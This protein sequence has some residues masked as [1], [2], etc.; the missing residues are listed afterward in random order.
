MWAPD[1]DH[2]RPNEMLGRRVF[3]DKP[4]VESG[5]KGLEGHFK[6]DIFFDRRL[7]DDLSVDRLGEGSPMKAVRRFLT[8]LARAQGGSMEPPRPFSGWAAISMKKLGFVEVMAAPTD[9]PRNPYHAEIS[10]ALFRN[11][12]QA[13]T[14]AFRLAA[15]AGRELVDPV[16]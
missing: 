9:E 13:E 12:V 4:F 2:I 16:G 1:P 5:G 7:G 8:P 3:T 11:K 6:I 14:L 10:R 15:E